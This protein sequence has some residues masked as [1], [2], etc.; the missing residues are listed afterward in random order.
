MEND[1]LKKKIEKMG[2]CIFTF[3]FGYL[4]VAFFLKSDYPFYNYSF[5]RNN[6]YEVLRD[7]LTLSAYFLAPAVGLVLFSDWRVQHREINREKQ[8]SEL[9]LNLERLNARFLMIAIDIQ[10]KQ[11]KTKAMF[12]EFDSQ[13][14]EV[15]LEINNIIIKVNSIHVND[16]T[17]MNFIQFYY[18]IVTNDFLNIYGTLGIVL[19]QQKILNFPKDYKNLFLEE[20][21]ETEFIERIRRQSLNMD[22][23]ILFKILKEIR[24]KLNNL[25]IELHKVIV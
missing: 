1:K 23:L 14:E 3:F 5:N 4:I 11:P 13:I 20:E 22:E 18:E 7:G 12:I 19:N 10:T 25:N 6:A 9:F 17:M 21:T 2:I 16:Q 15:N 24:E 8:A